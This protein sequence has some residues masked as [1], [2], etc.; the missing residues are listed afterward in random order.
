MFLCAPLKGERIYFTFPSVQSLVSSERCW[1][2]GSCC[3]AT[4]KKKEANDDSAGVGI[5]ASVC[6]HLVEESKQR[7]TSGI[8][9]FNCAISFQK[10]RNK[11]HNDCASP[12]PD[13]CFGHSPVMDDHFG[14]LSEESDLIYKRCGVSTSFVPCCFVLIPIF[15][16]MFTTGAKQERTQRL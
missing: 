6:S 2:S 7:P 3:T 11:G 12:D 10:L 1:G 15:M 14:K 5:C 16:L 9:S 8:L 4:Q 13:D